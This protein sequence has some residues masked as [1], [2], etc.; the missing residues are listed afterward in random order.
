MPRK[1]KPA[2]EGVIE[3]RHFSNAEE[4]ADAI[5]VLISHTFGQ[6]IHVNGLRLNLATGNEQ[7]CVEWR[8]EVPRA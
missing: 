3:P 1:N 8:R 7:V 6:Q 5:G 4:L 2:L